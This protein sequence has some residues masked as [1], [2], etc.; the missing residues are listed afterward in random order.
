MIKTILL[1]NCLISDWANV[2]VALTGLVLGFLSV[3][4]SHLSF[5]EASLV[6]KDIAR[7]GFV[8][9]QEECV[10]KLVRY[11][12]YQDLRFSTND[13]EE[14]F[15]GNLWG[16][17]VSERIRS[18]EKANIALSEESYCILDVDDFIYDVYLPKNIALVL[19]SIIRQ[20]KKQCEGGNDYIVIQTQ[21]PEPDFRKMIQGNTANESCHLAGLDVNS[22]LNNVVELRS[23]LKEWYSENGIDYKINLIEID[24]TK[25]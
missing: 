7:K 21:F 11:L 9:K 13:G 20:K 4:L 12:N 22:F 17:A 23:A 8:T 25:Y 10:A 15:V 18:F 16:V 5:K 24:K 2:I 1:S 19:R 6:R 14:I 3:K